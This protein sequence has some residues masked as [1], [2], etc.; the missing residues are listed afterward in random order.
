[1]ISWNTEADFESGVGLPVS[2]IGRETNIN[3]TRV[4]INRTLVR[5]DPELEKII[6]G[7]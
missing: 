4:N 6:D 7:M 3:L 5:D 2:K 1:M